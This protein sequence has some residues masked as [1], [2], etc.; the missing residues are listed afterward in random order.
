MRLDAT[1]PGWMQEASFLKI[2]LYVQPAESCVLG[3]RLL[4]DSCVQ[5]TAIVI[6]SCG[7]GTG[8]CGNSCGFDTGYWLIVAV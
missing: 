2:F 3:H 8:Y 7:L 4:D 6:D 1:G 5:D